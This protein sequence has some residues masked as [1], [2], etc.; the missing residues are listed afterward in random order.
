MSN[1]NPQWDPH[2][3]QQVKQ[4]LVSLKDEKGALL[5][6]LHEIQNT[7]GFIPPQSVA[8][9]ADALHQ[10]KAEIHGVITFYHHFRQTPPG[11]NQLEV[12]RAEACQARGSRSLEAH[13]K[14]TLGI[15]YHQ[16]SADGEFSLEPVYCLG[17]CSRGPSIRVGDDIVGDVSTEKFDNL[18]NK[19][20]T[21]VVELS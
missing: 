15:D 3:I 21:Y 4:I 9:I 6:I 5:P 7:L 2:V 16:T 12:C 14:S 18:V 1:N 19:L 20:T 8:M 11:R 10:T 13:V 17:N